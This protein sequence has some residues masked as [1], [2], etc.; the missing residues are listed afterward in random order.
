MHSHRLLTWLTIPANF[1]RLLHSTPT[2]C[3]PDIAALSRIPAIR[4]LRRAGYRSLT[5]PGAE[6]AA[7]RP[8]GAPA[9][10]RFHGYVIIRGRTKAGSHA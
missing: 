3:S 2:T 6:A 10:H 4:M 1:D 9:Q 8:I 5:T 7:Q